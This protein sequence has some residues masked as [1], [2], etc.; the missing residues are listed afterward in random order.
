MALILSLSTSTPKLL[1]VSSP[2]FKAL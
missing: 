2:E 1:A